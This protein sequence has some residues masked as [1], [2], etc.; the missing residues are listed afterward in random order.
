MSCDIG[1]WGLA[2]MGQNFALNMAEHGFSVAVGNRSPSKVEATVARAKAEGGLP[3][4]GSTGPADF[5]SQLSKPRKIIILVQAGK[6]V[7]DTIAQLA[8]HLEE[9]DIIV[10][11]GNEWFPNTIRRGK[12]LEEK[13]I[14]F[15]GMGISGGEEGARKGPSLMPGG[16]RAAY[17]QLENILTT[18]AAQVGD[19]ACTGYIGPVGSGNY[20]KMVHNGIEYGDMQLIAEVYDILRKVVGMSNQE[21]SKLFEEWNKGELES[22]LIEI[23]STILA[24]KDDITGK[25]EVVDYVLDKTGMKG[26]GRW[27]VQEAAEQSVAAP[28]IAASL[29]SRYISGRKSERVAAS[30]VLEGPT[31][32]PAVD[33]EQVIADLQAALYCAKVCSYAQGIGIIKAASEKNDWNINLSSCARMWRG[34][35]IIRAQLLAKI[36]QALA[37]DKDLP[38][39]MVDPTFAS[40]I[41]A[42]QMAWRRIVTLSVASGIACPA[43]SSSLTYFDQYRRESLPA[44]LVQAQRDFFGGH[45]YERTDKEGTFHTAW[46]DAHKDLGDLSGRTAGNV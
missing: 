30:K 20:V 17:D 22:F 34:G 3:I 28:T 39:L 8:E 23:T 21:M 33:K 2:V 40:E 32:Q 5:C 29:D 44:N 45:T 25:G 46:T 26:T 35:C 27:T 24:K 1:L 42:R 11:G 12:E 13:G 16:P 10:D 41:N 43:L 6:P 38:N 15:V 7:D 18:C 14:M 36:Q 4:V 9:G 19:E 37:I 31:E